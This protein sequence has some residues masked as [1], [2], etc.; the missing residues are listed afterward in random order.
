MVAWI[1]S[2]YLIANAAIQPIA[3]RLTDILTRKTGL[4]VCIVTFAFGNLICG[5]AK[6]RW[7][8]IFGRVMAGVGGGGINAI[9][10]FLGSDYIPFR[11]RGI[12][13]G[14]SNVVWASGAGLGGLFGGLVNDCCD[15]RM[16]FLML[17]P[18]SILSGIWIIFTVPTPPFSQNKGQGVR[19]EAWERNGF[20]GAF[21]LI[22]A[23]VFFLLGLITG[24]NILPW[25][26]PLFLAPLMVSALFFCV[27]IY[28]ENSDAK[29]P[30]IPLHLLLNRTVLSACLVC[31]LD[32]IFYYCLIFYGPI[33][34]QIR[35]SSPTKAGLYLTASSLGSAIGS[36]GAGLV[37]RMT[38]R[39]C[40]LSIFIQAALISAYILASTFSLTS[41]DWIPFPAFFLCGFGYTGTLTVTL[42]ALISAVDQSDQA[43]TTSASYAFRSTGSLI[44]ITISSAVFQ[45]ILHR[46]LWALL[47]DRPG[48]AEIIPRLKDNL[49][50]IWRLPRGG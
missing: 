12:W 46:K 33:Y 49:D 13:Q 36:I 45:N 34:L 29:E 44:G 9:C 25:T 4:L 23:L 41:P 28:V 21:T 22:G 42:T 32:S 19:Q 39:Y 37:M 16:A 35:H 11:R 47:G 8:M 15:W 3:W 43:V 31:W 17:V 40:F 48:A 14:M 27:F 10:T 26:H 6:L 50:E 30:I 5:L 7:V 38:G 24:G 1:A 2:S 20:L 18:L